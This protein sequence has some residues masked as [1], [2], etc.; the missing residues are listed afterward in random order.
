MIQI[1]SRASNAVNVGYTNCL[2]VSYG[3]NIS[4]KSPTTERDN[5]Q[6]KRVSPVSSNLCTRA[7][8]DDKGIV[9]LLLISDFSCGVFAEYSAV[10]VENLDSLGYTRIAANI[11]SPVSIPIIVCF[12]PKSAR[13][14]RDE[15]SCSQ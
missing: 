3:G 10:S 8:A 2:I 7:R 13:A 12:M 4:R 5:P 15:T 14:A 1:K 11:M 6:S 9:M